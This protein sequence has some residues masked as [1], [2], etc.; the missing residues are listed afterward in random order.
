M[1]DFGDGIRKKKGSVM[2]EDSLLE[3][4]AEERQLS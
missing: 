3:R 1:N 4:A 2:G